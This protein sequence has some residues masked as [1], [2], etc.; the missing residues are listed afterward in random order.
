MYP[1]L[2]CMLTHPLS[3]GAVLGLIGINHRHQLE[4]RAPQGDDSVSRPMAGMAPAGSGAKAVGLLEI[5]RCLVQVE[6]TANHVVDLQCHRPIVQ[7]QG[8]AFLPPA[9]RGGDHRSCGG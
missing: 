7:S 9:D 6:Y 1:R 8:E 3:E 2:R 5:S 4:V